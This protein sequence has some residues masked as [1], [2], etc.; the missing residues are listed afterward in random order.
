MLFP[1]KAAAVVDTV[2]R[3]FHVVP[4]VEYCQVPF[5]VLPVTAT[6][7]AAAPLSTS[8]SVN[9]PRTTDTATPAVVVSSV[10][11]VIVCGP[12]LNTGAS[13]TALT[14]SAKGSLAELPAASVTVTVTVAEPFLSDAGVAVTVRLAPLPPRAMLALGSRVVSDEL[15]AR[16]RSLTAMMLSPSR[17]ATAPVLAS[18]LIVCGVMSLIVGLPVSMVTLNALEAAL[19]FPAASVA[20]AVKLCVPSGMALAVMVQ[21]PLELAVAVPSDVEPP[22]NNSTVLLASA[23]PLITGVLLFVMLSVLEL[24]LSL[25]AARSRLAGASGMRVSIA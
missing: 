7:R 3:P 22:R 2:P 12:P 19:V 4:S 9:D 23:V 15:V 14:V 18:S 20:F 6:P 1:S 17:K 11:G 5:P 21:A 24:P 10:T 13:F 25:A 8:V 16:V